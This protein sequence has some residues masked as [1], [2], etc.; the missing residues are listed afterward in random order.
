MVTW[1]GSGPSAKVRPTVELLENHLRIRVV[2]DS[3]SDLLNILNTVGSR[4]P[5]DRY[6]HGLFGRCAL[7]QS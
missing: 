7:E 2:P 3:A 5:C 6:Y 1:F 4:L